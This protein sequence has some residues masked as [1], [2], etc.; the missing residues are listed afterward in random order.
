MKNS[1]KV[2]GGLFLA[3]LC[4]SAVSIAQT[5]TTTTQYSSPTNT[6]SVRTTTKVITQPT[7]V[8]SSSTPVR[9]TRTVTTTT[10]PTTVKSTTIDATTN[11]MYSVNRNDKIQQYQGNYSTPKTTTTTTQYSRPTTTKQVTTT[12]TTGTTTNTT[13]TPLYTTKSTATG[14]R[15]QQILADLQSQA[16]SELDYYE[17]LKTCTPATMDNGNLELKTYGMSNGLC[18]FDIKV[19]NTKTNQMTTLC[20]FN[21]PVESAKKF[22]SDKLRY[23]RSLLGLEKLTTDEYTDIA[24]NLTIFTRDNCKQQR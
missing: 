15:E 4:V 8:K 23:E 19:L 10:S 5:Y 14:S 13:K 18:G 21:V 1:V 24:T 3:V 9:T 12:T 2:F 11:P 17:K 20:T 22:A 7:V 16:Q 6:G